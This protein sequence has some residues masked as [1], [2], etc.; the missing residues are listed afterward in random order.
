MMTGKWWASFPSLPGCSQQLQ[1]NKGCA[2]EYHL[3]VDHWHEIEV[4]AI[5]I[6]ACFTVYGCDYEH[7]W[8]LLS[9]E[10]ARS[11]SK[12]SQLP[13]CKEG[14]LLSDIQLNFRFNF[15]CFEADI[16]PHCKHIYASRKCSRT[17]VMWLPDPVCYIM[18]LT[19]SLEYHVTKSRVES[20][21][22]HHFEHP[23]HWN[24]LCF[25]AQDHTCGHSKLSSN[26]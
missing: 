12:F 3:L 22:N 2:E 14:I 24:H 17:S 4:I 9:C 10:H 25:N 13:R 1:M 6:N 18:R 16:H 8:S 23:K 26:V 15:S 21:G 20:S 5:W 7:V 19:C 11:Q